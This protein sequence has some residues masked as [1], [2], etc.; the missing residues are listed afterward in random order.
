MG[1]ELGVGRRRSRARSDAELIAECAVGNDDALG[2][3]YDR[4][5]G[6]AYA[7]A[8]SVVRHV[9]LAEDVVQEAFLAIWRGA[10]R[11]DEKRG[12]AL[13]WLL[14]L[15]HHK[16]VDAVRREQCRPRPGM[17]V[18]E[19]AGSVCAHSR[20]EQADDRA[21][22]R[23]AVALLPAPQRRVL[24]LAYFDGFTQVQV[25]ALLGEPVGTIKSRTSAALG[26][27]RRDLVGHV[28]FP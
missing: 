17:C 18:D 12:T 19:Q 27:L 21:V 24:E 2:R 10:G 16:A 7:L 8:R 3:L 13:S 1:T 28:A 5:A 4:H 15:V 26:R 23:R 22:I 9:E 11:F 25:A 14:S 6:R 20:A